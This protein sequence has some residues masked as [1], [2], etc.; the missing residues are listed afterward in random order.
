MPA[1]L[2]SPRRWQWWSWSRPFPLA[3]FQELRKE[4]A[5]VIGFER[6]VNRTGSPQDDQGH[7]RTISVTSGR[8]ASPQ[9]DQ[10]HLRTIKV[11]SGRSASLQD[12]QGHLRTIK[13][14][15]GRSSTVITLYV[16]LKAH[17]CLKPYPCQFYNL[18]LNPYPCQFYKHCLK[19]HPCHL[20]KLA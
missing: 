14:T 17:L 19:R 6:P 8:S 12:D 9:D 18:C 20:Y 1:C 3:A 2:P 13:V 10:G 15:S 11:T 4:V 16:H 5:A 7:F